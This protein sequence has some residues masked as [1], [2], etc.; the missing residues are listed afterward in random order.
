VFTTPRGVMIGLTARIKLVLPP[1]L[2]CVKSEVPCLSKVLIPIMVG[3]EWLTGLAV[4]TAPAGCLP[5]ID[6]AMTT[7]VRGD[8]LVVATETIPG[9]TIALLPIVPMLTNIGL[10]GLRIMRGTFADVARGVA[11]LGDVL[12][13]EDITTASL[14]GEGMLGEIVVVLVGD[15]DI[16]LVTLCRPEMKLTGTGDVGSDLI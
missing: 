3:V 16:T 15:I 13:G 5:V 2:P 10:P 1:I 4:N 9:P 6:F 8:V 7:L 11:I 12:P 14:A